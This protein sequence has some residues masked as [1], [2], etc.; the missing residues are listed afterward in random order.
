MQTRVRREQ[1]S[2]DVVMLDG[3]R[4]N[5]D[6]VSKEIKS[7]GSIKSRGQAAASKHIGAWRQ[8]GIAC[9]KLVIGVC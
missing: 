7:N 3:D 2:G 9:G 6:G 8:E 4:P 1:S 5:C